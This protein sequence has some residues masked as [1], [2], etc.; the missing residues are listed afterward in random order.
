MVPFTDPKFSLPDISQSDLRIEQKSNSY[1]A[2]YVH[3]SGKKATD[4]YHLNLNHNKHKNTQRKHSK[5]ALN[6]NI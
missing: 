1:M 4:K 2:G 6:M 3:A 5:Y